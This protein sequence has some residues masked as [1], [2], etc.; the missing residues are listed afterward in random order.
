M[1]RAP[2]LFELA[3]MDVCISV[4][5]TFQ[6][7]ITGLNPVERARI[8]FESA[9]GNA[10][11]FTSWF[12]KKHCRENPQWSALVSF[13]YLLEEDEVIITFTS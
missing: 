13:Q 10:I 4:R 8:L 9:S 6:R 7:I 12:S 1:E 5:A 2:V 3:S 11:V